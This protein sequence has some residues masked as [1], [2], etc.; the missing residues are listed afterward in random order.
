MSFNASKKQP[1]LFFD[2]G[3][4]L[5][6]NSFVTLSPWWPRGEVGTQGSAIPH[7]CLMA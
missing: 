5:S 4:L 2:H 1:R 3:P 7:Q 6:L